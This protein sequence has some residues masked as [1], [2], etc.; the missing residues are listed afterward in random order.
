MQDY[1]RFLGEKLA[2]IPL[3]DQTHTYV[4]IEEVKSE[5]AIGLTN[6]A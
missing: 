3:I 1:Q 4:V 2:M 6:M 5:T